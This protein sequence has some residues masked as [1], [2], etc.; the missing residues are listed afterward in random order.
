MRPNPSNIFS[1]TASDF[2]WSDIYI[3]PHL[4]LLCSTSNTITSH[5][6]TSSSL[7]ENIIGTQS[8]QLFVLSPV[9]GALKQFNKMGK[10]GVRN[11]SL[12]LSILMLGLKMALLLF[13]YG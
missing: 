4:A 9:S 5:D 12:H 1:S 13:Y 6:S 8:G 11:G 2:S 7:L 3:K 10:V